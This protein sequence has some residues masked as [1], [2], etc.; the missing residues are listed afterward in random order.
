MLVTVHNRGPEAALPNAPQLWF[1]NI[2]SWR[3][4]AKRPRTCTPT[5][6]TTVGSRAC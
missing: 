5:A 3:L 6:L 1:R 4:N 2:W